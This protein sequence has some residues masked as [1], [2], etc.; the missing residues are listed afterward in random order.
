MGNTKE[1]RE[2]MV[3]NAIFQWNSTVYIDMKP[4]TNELCYQ[5]QKTGGFVNEM[6]GKKSDILISIPDGK[7]GPQ[8]TKKLKIEEI[9]GDDEME[10]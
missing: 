8:L 3:I 4:G 10:D 5:V 9:E 7:V 6:T 2:I 1:V